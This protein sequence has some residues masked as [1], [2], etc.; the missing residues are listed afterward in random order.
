MFSSL[1]IISGPSGAGEDSVIEGLSHIMPVER[2]I[3]TTTRAPRTG[4]SSGHPYH[5]ISPASFAEGITMGQFVEYAKQYNDNFYGVTKEELERVVQSGKVGIWKIEYQGV[6]TVKKL[7]P[8]IPS[9]FI[10]S[11]SID[12]LRVRI[13]RRGD[14]SEEALD[15]R[16]EYTKKWLK[17]KDIYDYTVVNEE[18]KL[19]ETIFRVRDIILSRSSSLPC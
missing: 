2:V 7:F 9:I 11:S 17:H 13:K 10:T 16:M 8:E 19:N 4:E 18:G 12:I 3:T 1:F 5:F 15:E 6:M 14:L